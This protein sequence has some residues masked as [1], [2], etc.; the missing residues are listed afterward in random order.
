MED[1]T[2]DKFCVRC[3]KKAKQS[4]LYFDESDIET[5]AKVARNVNKNIIEHI[6]NEVR[7]ELEK[8]RNLNQ[9]SIY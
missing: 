5:T 2:N 1:G 9:G 7:I 6:T 3:G 8:R 4:Y